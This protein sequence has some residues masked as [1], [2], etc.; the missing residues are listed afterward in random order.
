MAKKA[1]GKNLPNAKK[2]CTEPASF[3]N[4]AILEKNKLP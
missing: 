1:K 4:I 3:V 2:Y